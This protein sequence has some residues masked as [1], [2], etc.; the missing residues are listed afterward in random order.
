MRPFELELDSSRR[1]C[2]A[3]TP[4]CSRVQEG[5]PPLDLLGP[6]L[7]AI[8]LI[9]ERPTSLAEKYRHF[10]YWRQVLEADDN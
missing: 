9:G 8:A 6:R 2:P 10:C 7:D 1:L 5:R 3:F 4:P